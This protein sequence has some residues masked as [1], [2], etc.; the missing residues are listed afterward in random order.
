M[1]YIP[2]DY[3]TSIQQDL[4]LQLS[5]MISLIANR[6][7]EEPSL[8]ME[9]AINTQHQACTASSI[10]KAMDMEFN[11]GKSSYAGRG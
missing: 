5:Y 9:M 10:S 3:D 4:Y 1:L 8:I 7:V 2:L 11:K 6:T